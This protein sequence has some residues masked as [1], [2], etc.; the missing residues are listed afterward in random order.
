ME[1]VAKVGALKEKSRVGGKALESLS[2]QS[3]NQTG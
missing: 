3:R 1:S 2:R